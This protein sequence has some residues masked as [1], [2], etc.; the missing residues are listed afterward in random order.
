MIS[1]GGL[2]NGVDFGPIVDFLV[3]AKRIPIDRINERKL[4][5]QEKL[6]NFGSLGTKLLGLQNAA[7]SLRTRLSFDKNEVSVSSASSQTLLTASASSTAGSG[8]Y[9]VTVNEL[10][11]AH[12]IV[13][14][15]STAVSTTDADIVSGA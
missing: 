13:S 11:S 1:F 8:T 7:N 2:G 14:K 9:T 6:T 3:Q 12:Q 5:D 4:N 10:A 15:A